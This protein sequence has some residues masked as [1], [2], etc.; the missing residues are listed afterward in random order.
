MD[1]DAIPEF[2]EACGT[3][4]NRLL[5][6]MGSPFLTQALPP[7]ASVPLLMLF[8]LPGKLFPSFPCHIL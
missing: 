6:H 8:L 2:L 7:A 1:D 3:E 4:T 5:F